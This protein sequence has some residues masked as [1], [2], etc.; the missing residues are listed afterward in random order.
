MADRYVQY[1]DRKMPL[2]PGV[3]LEQ[4]K[5]L[6]ARHFPELADP[7][8]ETKNDGETTVYVFTKKAGHKGAGAPPSALARCVAAL[9][10][11]GR[12]PVVPAWALRIGRGHAP[13]RLG[14]EESA[15][16]AQDLE[17]EA[18]YARA[19]GDVLLDLPPAVTPR[20]SVL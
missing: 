19:A 13:S 11:L 12:V 8:V 2:E 7:K 10:E 4:A 14:R 20:G 18:A 17:R 5:E 3:T 9:A 6:M 1:G 16:L 15:E